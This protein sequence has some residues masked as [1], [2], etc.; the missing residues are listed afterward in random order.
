VCR[1]LEVAASH[2]CGVIL[3]P[4]GAEGQVEGGVVMGIGMATLEGSIVGEDGRQKNPHLLDY[5][6]Q[7]AADAPPI[8]IA[9]VDA[10]SPYGGPKGSKGTGEPPCV[11]TPGAIGN[12][13]PVTGA[14]HQPPR[15]RAGGR[16]RTLVDHET[17]TYPPS[18]TGP[19]LLAGTT[20]GARCHGTDLVVGTRRTPP[21]TLVAIH[22]L[23]NLDGIGGTAA[24]AR[25]A[26]THDAIER[27]AL[28]R[29]DGR[30]GR[31]SAM[32]ARPPP[33]T[34]GRRREPRHALPRWR[35]GRRSSWARGGAGVVRR[36][37]YRRNRGQGPARAATAGAG[38]SPASVITLPT[39]RAARTSGSSS[40]G[41][42]RSRWWERPRS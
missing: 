18:S 22:L 31:A 1:V 13:R 38:E 6:L 41:R 34:S 4:V 42:W 40:G 14:A 26:P 25:R 29:A 30:A 5:K 12:N 10:P 23:P 15:P 32:S 20:G 3:N 17:G 2:D 9:F 39:A 19:G 11:P 21:D 8:S 7:T 28:V 35:P 36:L 37:A 24:P 16:R 27:S 33:A